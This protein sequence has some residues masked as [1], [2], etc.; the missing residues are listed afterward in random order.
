[1]IDTITSPQ[2]FPQSER[3]N[4]E[5]LHIKCKLVY[6]AKTPPPLLVFLSNKQEKFDVY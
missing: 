1:M 5:L 6:S 4:R 2:R 3:H